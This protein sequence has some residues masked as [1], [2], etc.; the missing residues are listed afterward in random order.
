MGLLLLCVALS[1]CY[2][3]H[4]TNGQVRIL[5]A[6]RPIPEALA[7]PSL[8][9]DERDRLAR[10]VEV[11]AF[12]ETLGLEVDG[13]YRDYVAWPGDRIV[14]TVVATRPRE[15]E[16]AGFWFPIVGRVPYKGYFDPELAHDQAETL[17]ADGLDVCE[18]SVRAYS[19]LGWFDDPVTGPMLRQ[20]EGDLVETLL[21]ELVHAT[22]F[23][24]SQPEF[25]E[26]VASFIGQEARV[27]FYAEHDGVAEA[28][29]QQARVDLRRRIRNEMLVLRDSIAE[30]YA[31]P[32]AANEIDGKRAEFEAATRARVAAFPF[33]D[34]RGEEIATQLRLNDACLALTATYGGDAH[35][36]EA[37]L[38][39]RGGELAALIAALRDAAEA[40]DPRAALI[41]ACATL[42]APTDDP[43]A[44]D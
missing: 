2:L 18:V 6:R 43:R 21:H 44:S 25:N 7:D 22:A 31:G 14:T 42:E 1:G 29:S 36:Y 15:I 30:L 8:P 37:A 20:P 27:R 11:R 26:G 24:S 28:Q 33:E 12:A 23:V 9:E 13:S 40:D 3:A 39:S 32:A 34:G 35:C 5:W 41:G 4:V 19:T 10:V 38:E 16:P 17:R